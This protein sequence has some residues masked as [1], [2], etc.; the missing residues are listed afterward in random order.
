C[1]AKSKIGHGALR[2]SRQLRSPW[3]S[4]DNIS[5]AGCRYRRQ[6][7]SID[8]GARFQH[9]LQEAEEIPAEHFDDIRLLKTAPHQ[10]FRDVRQVVLTFEVRYQSVLANAEDL[11]LGIKRAVV[12]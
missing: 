7:K 10:A 3:R 5:R 6:T 9:G 12:P 2:P 11:I 8:G 4:R 1:E